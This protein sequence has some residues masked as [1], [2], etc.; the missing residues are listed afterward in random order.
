MKISKVVLRN[1]KRFE[2]ETFHLD[3]NVVLTGPNNSG[4]TTLLQAIGAWSLAL[5]RWHELGDT[6]RRHGGYTWQHIIRQQFYPVPLRSF[7]SLWHDRK[8][9]K[10]NRI[11]IKVTTAAGRIPLE[12]RAQTDSQVFAR[13]TKDADREVLKK[14]RYFPRCAFVP[15]MSGL[16]I[17]EPVLQLPRIDQ[18]I[19]FGKPGDILRNLLVEAHYDAEKWRGIAAAVEEIFGYELL[20]PIA[21]GP[22]II[23]EYRPRKDGP[24]FDINSAGSGF[25]QILMLL[26]FMCTWKNTVLLLDAPDAHLHMTMQDTIYG[27]LKTFARANSVQLIIATHSRT[28]IDSTEPRNL[29]AMPGELHIPEDGSAGLPPSTPTASTAADSTA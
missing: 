23:A 19:G 26:T 28:L 14:S 5:G 16:V 21:T 7:D 29:R 15:P 10:K 2:E 11:E 12:F 8:Y 18:L 13:P 27:A 17:D 22:L 25:L 24:A 1:F 20:P 4:K 3:G 9:K 6:Q